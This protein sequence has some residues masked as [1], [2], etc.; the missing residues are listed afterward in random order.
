MFMDELCNLIIPVKSLQGNFHLQFSSGQVIGTV[1]VLNLNDSS[2][3]STFSTA[4]CT[5]SLL[6]VLSIKSLFGCMREAVS[7][8]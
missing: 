8:E 5:S 7:R 6:I 3:D 2:S 1:F 4:S